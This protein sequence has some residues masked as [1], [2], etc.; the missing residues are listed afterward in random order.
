MGPSL[1]KGGGP[2][3]LPGTMSHMS[4]QLSTL[5][6]IDQLRAGHLWRRLPQLLIGL[7]LYGVSMSLMIRSTL[8]AMPWDVLHLGLARQLPLDVGQ[9]VII[10]SFIVLL[11]W[12]PLREVPGIGTVLNAILIGIA[13]DT[14]LSFLHA[15]GDWWLRGLLMVSG[16]CLN[17]VATAMYIGAQFG[18][19]PRDG[20][21]TGFAR[22]TGHSIRLVRSCLEVAVVIVGVLLG[23][24][25]GVGTVLYAV[26]IGPLTQLLLPPFLVPLEANVRLEP[27]PEAC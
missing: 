7:W 12:I 11:G 15:P 10:V 4:V 3:R 20:L 5:G 18:R 16:I 2:N 1:G 8:G 9:I 6:P 17:A 26:L 24:T 19:G 25:L 23:G 13:T 27:L 14:M 22:R 21:M